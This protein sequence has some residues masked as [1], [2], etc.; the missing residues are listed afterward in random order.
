MATID[1]AM[2]AFYFLGMLF[3]G[4]LASRKV[5]S[6]QDY[7]IAGGKLGFP[8]LLGTLVAT[9][10]GGGATLGRAGKAYEVGIAIGIASLAYALGLFLFTRLSPILRRN[11]IWTIPG[12][13][14]MRFGP[15]M[16]IAVSV[17]ILMAIAALFSAQLI[18]FGL[19]VVALSGDGGITYTQAILA[20]AFI[21]VA[22][23]VVGGFFAV[24]YTD[25]VQAV[26]M[27]LGIGIMLPWLVMSNLD[28]P[29][30]AMAHLKPAPGHLLGGMGVMFILSFFVIDIPAALVDM[31]LWQRNAAASSDSQMKTALYWTILVY[32]VWSVIAIALGI[33]ASVL[34][35]ELGVDGRGGD[36]AIPELIVLYMP[37][38]AK[39]L[40]LAALMAVM[41]STADTA[42]LLGGTTMGFDVVQPLRP[43]IEDKTVM[44]V[45]RGTIIAIGI[46][47]TLIALRKG[48]IFEIMLLTV[49]VYVSGIF[50]PTMAALFSR[51]ATSTAALVSLIGATIVVLLS[52]GLRKIDLL[53]HGVEPIFLGLLASVV[54]LV[55]VSVLT[56]RS[57]VPTVRLV[58]RKAPDNMITE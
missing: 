12:A 13:L 16:R 3:V 33:W 35:P 58:D 55:D 31:S 49:A 2:I 21:M 37:P 45:T 22:Y 18:A 32:V 30:V 5:N 53:P 42:L 10:I 7:A 54:L 26:I 38:V 28:G 44:R 1:L 14:A 48:G 27:V 24:A 34:I 51:R 17:V 8:V 52:Y 29:A 47:G 25:L 50:F 56:A 57:N 23:T 46:I 11:Q 4:Y 9:Q 41:M 43:G 6:V 40:C 36:A 19:A 39:G 20:A 15:T